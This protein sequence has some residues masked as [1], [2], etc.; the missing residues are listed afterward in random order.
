MVSNQK[1]I[2]T[3]LIKGAKFSSRID[4][5]GKTKGPEKATPLSKSNELDFFGFDE[6]QPEESSMKQA[7][8]GTLIKAERKGSVPSLP[9]VDKETETMDAESDDTST[10]EV[11]EGDDDDDDDDDDDAEKHMAMFKTSKSSKSKKVQ[12]TVQTAAQR[13]AEEVAVFRKAMHIR[14]TGDVIPHPIASFDEM[15]ISNH[16]MKNVLLQNIEKSQYKEPTAVQM[17]AIP[18]VLSKRDTLAIAPTGSGKTAAFVLPILGLL[19]TPRNAQLKKNDTNEIRAVVLAP[20][21]ELAQ[22]IHME[23][24]RL[25]HGR[26]IRMCLLSKATAAN[27]A[28]EFKYEHV[29]FIHLTIAEY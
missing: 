29:D 25:S 4:H 14:V 5:I 1:L 12:K 19:A 7:K 23:F 2:L 10:S 15:D 22:Q 24:L 20:T 18:A 11:D 17:Q 13:K 6:P 27:V 16:R 28:N 3:S 26:K 9:A 8:E 21:K